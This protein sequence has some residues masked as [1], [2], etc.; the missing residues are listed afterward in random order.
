MASRL[1]RVILLLYSALVRSHLQVLHSPL[2][3]SVKENVELLEQVQ[4]CQKA[5][6]RV[7]ATPL[8]RQSERAGVAQ[9]GDHHC[10]LPVLKGSMK[11]NGV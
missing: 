7:K 1:R 8:W 5:D 11:K 2:R 3:S 4:N 6:L 10:S 9:P